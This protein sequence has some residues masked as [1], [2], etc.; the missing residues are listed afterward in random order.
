MPLLALSHDEVALPPE[1]FDVRGW[2]VRTEPDDARVGRVEDLLLEPEGTPRYLV[3]ALRHHDEGRLLIPLSRA[4][5][6]ASREVVWVSAFTEEGLRAMPRYAGDAAAVSP[7]VEE[8]LLDEYRRGGHV[9]PSDDATDS[10]LV[11]LSAMDEHRVAKGSADPRGWAVVGG[12]GQKV[13]KVAELLVD[14][15]A[16]KARYVDC[17]VDED[18]LELERLDRH[19][20]VPMERVRLDHDDHRVVVD[21]LFGRDVAR[22]PVYTGLPLSEDAERE[23]GHWFERPAEGAPPGGDWADRSAK[24]FFGASRRAPR[25]GEDAA[26]GAG[27]EPEPSAADL[28]RGGAARVRLPEH[29]EVRIRVSGDDIVIERGPGTERDHG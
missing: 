20:L 13:G 4:W 28:S 2:E 5:A 18:L 3:V 29:G 22:Y 8:R 25:R 7:E 16:M 17:D 10:R 19:V 9:Q 1:A 15:G 23:I 24:R 27:A 11:R 12:D 14:R 21:G 26:S 6:D